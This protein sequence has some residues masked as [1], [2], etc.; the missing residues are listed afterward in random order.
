MWAELPSVPSWETLLFLQPVLTSATDVTPT[1]ST[2]YQTPSTAKCT[3]PASVSGKA[4]SVTP[5]VYIS[6]TPHTCD[7]IPATSINKGN[8]QFACKTLRGKDV[9]YGSHTISWL[10]TTGSVYIKPYTFVAHPPT[11]T[12]KYVVNKTRATNGL[13]PMT[14]V[15]VTATSSTTKDWPSTSTVRVPTSTSTCFVTVTVTPTPV[16]G[17]P[18]RRANLRPNAESLLPRAVVADGLARVKAND[19]RVAVTRNMAAAATVKIGRPDFTYPPLP[20]TTI[21]V[22]SIYTSTYTN[23][24]VSTFYTGRLVGTTTVGYLS[25]VYGGG[26]V[27]V[28]ATP[29]SQLGT[30]VATTIG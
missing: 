15:T 28:T 8:F 21:Y 30:A 29:V 7:P 23:L 1:P 20:V 18:L 5:V 4:Y 2:L 26:T 11:S 14:V 25:V 10:P 13:V 24:H 19:K 12:T 9:G 16:S 27:T 3:L 17:P 6:R 22:K